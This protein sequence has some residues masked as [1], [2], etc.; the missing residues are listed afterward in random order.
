MEM[1]YYRDVLRPLVESGDVINYELQ[2]TYELQPEFVHD[3]K[4]VKAITYVADY[5]I[6]YKDGNEIV[7]DIKGC[8]DPKALIKRK[9]FWYRYPDIDY[10]WLCFSKI[11]GGWCTYE[12]VKKQRAERR[13]TRKAQEELKEKQ[14][15]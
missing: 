2:K 10:Q 11:D 13:K 9:M 12:Y 5:Y 14:N 8:P 3:N 15:E 4:K 7:I 6:Q 1:K